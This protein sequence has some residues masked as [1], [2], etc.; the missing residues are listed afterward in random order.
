MYSFENHH[1]NIWKERRKRKR[2][3]RWWRRGEL[4]AATRTETALLA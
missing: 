3:R 1:E 2:R 4:A